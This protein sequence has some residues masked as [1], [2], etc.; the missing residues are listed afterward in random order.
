MH[1]LRSA[2][3]AASLALIPACQEEGPRHA[4]PS[5]VE[6][7][8]DNLNAI[9]AGLREYAETH[10]RAP[11]GSGVALF[12][13]LVR[14]GT[15]D[16]T[17]AHRARLTCPGPGATAARIDPSDPA[18][19]SSASAY[20][21][22]DQTRHPLARFPA[23]GEHRTI[24]VACDNA[25]GPNHAGVVN[26]LYSDGTIRTVFLS[27]LIENGLLEPGTESIPVG[28]GSPV[29]DLNLLVGD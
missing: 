9:Y 17:P 14:E 5:D 25:N 8:K 21:G 3:L 27:R 12:T 20:A 13:A 10:G 22:L 26:A 19:P 7:C 23:G 29:D 2:V 18:P 6:R 28:P 1:P 15:W 11:S 4:V 24:L 16:D